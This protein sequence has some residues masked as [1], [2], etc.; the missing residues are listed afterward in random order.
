MGFEEIAMRRW[1]TVGALLSCALALAEPEAAVPERLYFAIE[2]KHEGRVIG[3]PRLLGESGK[4]LRVE[5]RRPGAAQF[6][7]RLALSPSPAEGQ[8]G[9]YDIALDVVLP[10]ARGGGHF[11]LLHGEQRRLELSGRGGDLE[12]SLL[13]MKVD[14]PEFRALMDLTARDERGGA[15]T[16]I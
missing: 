13:V 15:A 10:D 9:R 8:R 7:Y 12:V 14:S 6:D 11:S 1:V 3:T 5:R 16:S 4:L 2:L